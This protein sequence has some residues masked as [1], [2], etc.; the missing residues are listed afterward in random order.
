MSSISSTTACKDPIK[1]S[2]APTPTKDAID[3]GRHDNNTEF[4]LLRGNGVVSIAIEKQNGKST[5]GAT[6]ATVRG[7]TK[8]V[9]SQL[10][11]GTYFFL[12][13]CTSCLFPFMCTTQA[14]SFSPSFIHIF[15]SSMTEPKIAQRH[16]RRTSFNL[17][18]A[19]CAIETNPRSNNR[20]PLRFTSR[21]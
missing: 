7:R 6:A 11:A 20:P 21:Q 18:E 2:F 17:Q 15:A 3:R 1:S 12:P 16:S 13:R 5:T 4:R 8:A 10:K 19:A 14:F 9:C